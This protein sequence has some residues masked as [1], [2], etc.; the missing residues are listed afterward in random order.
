MIPSAWGRIQYAA[1]YTVKNSSSI[2]SPMPRTWE[3][4]VREPPRAVLRDGV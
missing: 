2:D 3:A 1:P 4:G